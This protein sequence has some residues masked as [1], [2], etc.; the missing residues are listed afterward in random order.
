MSVI[1]FQRFFV[2]ASATTFLA[3]AALSGA[4]GPA[5]ASTGG[6]CNGPASMQACITVIEGDADEDLVFEARADLGTATAPSCRLRLVSFDETTGWRWESSFAPCN[7]PGSQRKEF[8]LPNPTEGHVYRAELQILPNGKNY[9]FA[10]FVS[11][12][13]L[14]Y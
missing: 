2:T 4:A 5:A 1:T 3:G 6:G 12:P 13:L 11:S 8:V 9:E 7:R 10:Q 14:T